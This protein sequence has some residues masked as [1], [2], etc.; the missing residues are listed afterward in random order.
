MKKEKISKVIGELADR[1]IEDALY[2]EKYLFF[3]GWRRWQKVVACVALISF[4]LF[5]MTGIAF[6]AN[7]DFRKMVVTFV[8]GFSEKEKEQIRKGHETTS[9]DRTDVLV[10]FLHDYNDNNMGNGVKAK[11]GENGF[12]YIVLEE[13]SKNVN[14]IVNCESEQL[15]LLV[16]LR[17][18]EMEGGLQAWKIASYQMV[19]CEEADGL[20]KSFSGKPSIPADEAEDA[21]MQNESK[22]SQN[23]VI[24]ASKEH[25]KI[26]H[27]LHKE[28][29]NIITL[30]EEETTEVKS[31]FGGYADDELGWEG[32]DYNYIILFDEVEYVITEDGFVIKEDNN[33]TS[34]FKMKGQDLKKVMELFE[35]YKIKF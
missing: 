26:Y 6:A 15:K 13:G 19:T 11:Y 20:L 31:I 9:L 3:E 32:Q 18:E 30:S 1:H 2:C 21:E 8:S 5:G 34:A 23:S 14:I 27:A 12:D 7:A 10:E 33:A 24:T 22:D 4:C 35:R 17:G 16:N 29:E 25:G 28:K